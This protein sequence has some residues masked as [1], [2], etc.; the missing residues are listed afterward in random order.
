VRNLSIYT[1]W[2][3]VPVPKFSCLEVQPPI[4]DD[5]EQSLAQTTP[6]AE[7]GALALVEEGAHAWVC[8]SNV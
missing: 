8:G 5:L 7:A 1:Y 3:T 4:R 2:G 6:P